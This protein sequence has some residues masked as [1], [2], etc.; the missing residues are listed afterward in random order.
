MTSTVVELRPKITAR[1]SDAVYSEELRYSSK[2]AIGLDVLEDGT[3]V[4]FRQVEDELSFV[5]TPDAGTACTVL[6]LLHH[7]IKASRKAGDLS[8]RDGFSMGYVEEMID[9]LFAF[10]KPVLKILTEN[11][12]TEFDA[13]FERDQHIE[14]WHSGKEPDFS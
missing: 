1:P 2:V 8:Y 3:A 11:G 14:R 7:E 5:P 12:C 6:L 9:E 13:K 4:V 10:Y